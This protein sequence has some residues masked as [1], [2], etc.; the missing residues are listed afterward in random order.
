M[1]FDDICEY[2]LEANVYK[3]IETGEEKIFGIPFII[4]GKN[5]IMDP[6]VE[7][8]I[9]RISPVDR[10]FKL[11]ELSKVMSS[12]AKGITISAVILQQILTDIFD[13]QKANA[14]FAV[15]RPRLVEPL[16][17]SG[18]KSIIV[19]ALQKE[20][21]ISDEDAMTRKAGVL[22]RAADRIFPWFAKQKLIRPMTQLDS[23]AGA[24]IS[25]KAI[26]QREQDTMDSFSKHIEGG[27]PVS[28]P[29]QEKDSI[30][31]QDVESLLGYMPKEL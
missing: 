15:S 18:I 6:E 7:S 9:S 5:M 17:V 20:N 10:T 24:S 16:N 28:I 27:N 30:D 25:K 3:D 13:T 11:S 2:V 29:G 19:A 22:N 1:K 23:E 26:K 8:K 4:K 12:Q 14:D 21:N 31:P